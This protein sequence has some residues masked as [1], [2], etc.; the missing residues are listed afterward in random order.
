MSHGVKKTLCYTCNTPSPTCP[1]K[2]NF[3]PVKGWEAEPTKVLVSEGKYQNSYHVKSCPLYEENT[4][5]VEVVEEVPPAI[6]R[7][8]QRKI[9]NSRRGI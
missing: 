8:I 5:R 7:R 9:Y 4:R 3:T 2:Y 6:S 1:W